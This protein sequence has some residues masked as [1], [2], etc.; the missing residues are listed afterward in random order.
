M[1]KM[2]VD[3]IRERITIK[4]A[5]RGFEEVMKID[6]TDDNTKHALDIIRADKDGDIDKV[7]ELVQAGYKKER[8][9]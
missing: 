1:C 8:W 2:C 7:K 6:R 9:L 5:L 4:E 3:I